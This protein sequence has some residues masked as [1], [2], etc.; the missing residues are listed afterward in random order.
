MPVRRGG[1]KRRKRSDLTLAQELELLIGSGGDP[2][3]FESEDD[4]RE[5]WVFNRE[6]LLA[7][8]P[9]RVKPLWG[10]RQ[11]DGAKDAYYHG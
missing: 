8:H 1:A 9:D 4:R 3:A 10:E 6:R 2:S 7:D 11:Y 5:A